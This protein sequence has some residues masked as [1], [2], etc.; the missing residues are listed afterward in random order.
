[1]ATFCVCSQRYVDM[2]NNEVVIP[3]K[4]LLEFPE[5][6]AYAKETKQLYAEL[7]RLGVPKEDARFILP[8]G[9]TT[10]MTMTMN[11]RSLRHFL[12]LRLDKK[13]QWEVQQVAYQIYKICQQK[14]GWLVEDLSYDAM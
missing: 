12:K 2:S 13:A 5:V 7:V 4:L 1:M 8:E 14:W 6:L 10:S 11:F 3:Q 9:I